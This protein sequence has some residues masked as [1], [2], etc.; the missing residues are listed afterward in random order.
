MTL[1]SENIK[2]RA[3]ELS[4]HGCGIASIEWFKSAPEGFS[5]KDVYSKCKNVISFFSQM[6]KGAIMAEKPIPYT[7][8]YKLYEEMDEIYMELLRFCQDNGVDAVIV[9]ADTPY[10]L[11]C[12][13]YG[14]ERNNF[15]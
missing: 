3:F 9:P 6:P 10:I 15:P 12:R 13:K 2:K 7:H 11:A 14:W 1:T 5:P 4:A 8:A